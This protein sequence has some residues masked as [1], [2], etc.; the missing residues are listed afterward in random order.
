[1]TGVESSSAISSAASNQS[2][3]YD[4]DYDYENSSS[5]TPSTSTV[6]TCDLFIK[7]TKRKASSSIESNNTIENQDGATKT[8]RK[9]GRP[10]KPHVLIPLV[11]ENDIVN[12]SEAQRKYVTERAKNNVASRKSR[13]NRRDRE[14]KFEEEANELDEQYQKLVKEE[15]RLTKEREKWKRAVMQ[16]TLL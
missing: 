16:L 12:L 1:M 2:Y 10:A 14:V 5:P 13:A 7:P 11:P 8:K 3:S 9:R 15:R 6:D 4:E